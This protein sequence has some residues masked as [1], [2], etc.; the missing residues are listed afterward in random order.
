VRRRIARRD[1]L[2]ESTPDDGA[3]DGDDG[4]DGHLARITGTARL[5]ERRGHQLVVL[6]RA[7]TTVNA[8]PAEST[9]ISSV[10]GSLT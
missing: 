7:S 6:H 3:V 9:A 10:I 2:I 1:R 8:E 5:V 4:A